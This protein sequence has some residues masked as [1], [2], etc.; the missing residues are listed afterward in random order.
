[1]DAKY[2]MTVEE[3]IFVAKRNIVDYI[4]K[5]A[6]LEGLGV[7]Y[8]ETEAIYNGMC[9]PNVRV[10]DIVAVNNLKHAWHFILDTIDCPTNLN[11]ICQTNRYVGGDNLIT[12]AGYLRTIPVLMG[13]TSWRPDLPD[14]DKINHELN[15][16]S[17]IENP[18]E[19]AITYMLYCTRTQ[20]F[21]D[22]NKRTSMLIANHE[23]IRNGCG[24][25]TVP[26]EKQPEFTR[27]LVDYYETNDMEKIKWYTYD[28]CIDG[29]DFRTQ[30]R[31]NAEQDKNPQSVE[32][33][34]AAANK[35]YTEQQNKPIQPNNIKHSDIE[36]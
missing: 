9:A 16:I 23:M 34:A 28:N 31:Y 24:I 7:T 12:N 19:R 15:R 8:P 11:Y 13:G 33:L 18:T 5:S 32:S 3:N 2:N 21:T 17:E 20:M 1:M 35:K 26:I 6:R 30:E 22:G 10:S 14:K 36:I 29:M 4:W 27:M 25:I